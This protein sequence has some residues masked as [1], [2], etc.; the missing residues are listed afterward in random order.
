MNLQKV[1][2]AVV[3]LSDEAKKYIKE[4]LE[5][6]AMLKISLDRFPNKLVI[7]LM[8]SYE[9]TSKYMQLVVGP[10]KIPVTPQ[11]ANDILG[12]PLGEDDV[13]LKN[14]LDNVQQKKR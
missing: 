7:D 10:H 14:W 13:V 1:K 12:L 11:V 8:E 6:G 2:D 5:L 9:L 4:K 3:V